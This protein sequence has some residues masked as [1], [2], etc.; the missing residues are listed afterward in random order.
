MVTMVILR[1]MATNAAIAEYTLSQPGSYNK[2]TCQDISLWY[3]TMLCRCKARCDYKWCAALG[4]FTMMHT[5]E[6]RH[7]TDTDLKQ[8]NISK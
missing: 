2:Y 4:S 1:F 7:V 5:A 6:V 3:R 8:I